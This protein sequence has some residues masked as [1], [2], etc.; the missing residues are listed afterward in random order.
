MDDLTNLGFGSLPSPADYRDIALSSVVAPAD[1]PA[2]Y[3]VDISKLTRRNQRKIGACVGHAGSTYKQK[4]DELDTKSIILLSPR[5]LYGICKCIDGAPG[6]GTYPRTSMSV[7][8]NHGVCTDATLPNDTTL[9]H[10]AYVMSRQLANF[11]AYMADAA[12]Y[13]IASYAN[14]D[15]TNIDGVKQ[16]I[17]LGNGFSGLVKVG[18]EWYSDKNGVTWDPSR[19]LPIKAPS[20]VISGHQVYFYGYEDSADG[21]DTKVYFLNSWSEQWGENGTGWFWWSEYRSYLIEGYTAIDVPQALLDEAHNLP[22]PN[23]FK[24]LFVRPMAYGEATVDVKA[25]QKALQLDGVFPATQ[26]ITGFYGGITASAVIAFQKKYNVA[27]LV[28]ILFLRGRKCGPKT[29]AKLNS[30]FNK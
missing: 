10:E 15:V 20:T 8:K 13:K 12:K 29:L 6:E 19:I 23:A 7:L 18:P 28:E 17:I 14:V 22:P 27:S 3:F 1:Q 30:L 5:F 11:S 4:L 25:L 24:Y 21:L 16:G 26:E 2:K 9:D